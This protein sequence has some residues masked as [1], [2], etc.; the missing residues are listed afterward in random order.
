MP[1]QPIENYG[2]IGNLHTAALVGMDDSIDWMCIP[3]FGSPSVFAAILDDQKG[4][5]FRI[6]A[7]GDNQSLY[8]SPAFD[9]GHERIAGLSFTSFPLE[10][11]GCTGGELR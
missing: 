4:G 8:G 1:Y 6:W 5:R 11:V 9:A 2:L 10:T 3:H 7:T